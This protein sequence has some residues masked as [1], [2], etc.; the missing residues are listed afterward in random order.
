MIK[1]Y[2]SLKEKD[3]DY[4]KF[5]LK[6]GVVTAKQIQLKFQEPNIDRVYR[7]MRKLVDRGYAKHERIAHKVGV[8]IG[9]TEARS[10]TEIA[11]TVPTKTSL[12]TMQHELLLTD[13]ALYHEFL[14]TGKGADFDYIS[15]REYRFSIIGS[16]EGGQGLKLYNENKERI[17]DSVYS[18]TSN[19]VK[20]KIWIE[21]ELNK[22]DHKRYEEKFKDVFEPALQSGDYSAVWYF[23]DSQKV[24]NAIE[25]AKGQLLTGD[26]V[27]VFDIPQ[28]I[29]K[30]DWGKVVQL[31]ESAGKP[32]DKGEQ[33]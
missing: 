3:Y 32:G 15:E 28:V 1:K 31:N 20:Q 10:I 33:G 23:T 26:K 13:L 9:T 21:L 25:K 14:F 7:R 6:N 12:Y 19:G 5:I 22:K 8:Y 4:M 2:S 11:A 18:I 30:D 16:G 17:P 27:K 29:L 24:K